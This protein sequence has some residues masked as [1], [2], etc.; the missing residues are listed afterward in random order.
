MDSVA[1]EPM[2]DFW[3]VELT[4]K[5]RKLQWPRS[6]EEPEPDVTVRLELR[7]ACL[8]AKAK[9]GER[10]VVELTAED[11]NGQEVTHA[12]L[13]LSVG[14]TEQSPLF[15]EVF[16]PVTFNLASGSGPL[17]IVGTVHTEFDETASD[18]LDEE[19]VSLSTPELMKNR[20][21]PAESPPSKAAKTM[22]LVKENGDEMETSVGQENG[23]EESDDE[24][25]SDSEGE[26]EDEEEDEEEKVTRKTPVKPTVVSKPKVKSAQKPPKS[27]AER[28]QF[29]TPQPLKGSK[30]SGKVTLSAPAT[31]E[32][33]S[34]SAKKIAK[35]TM[36]IEDMKEKLKKTPNLPKKLDKFGNYVQHNFKLTDDKIKKELW[37]FAQKMRA[38]K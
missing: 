20:K 1:I 35:S 24:E 9:P 30:A 26:E 23:S 12:I 13:S 15:L 21:R 36:S 19:D 34:K 17:H 4:G 18:E 8:G 10:N 32:Q 3:G 33:Q 28:P 37:E 11:E 27:L 31:P 38:A 14:G 7:Q 6:G 5:H 25:E 29:K 2:F 16:P 22:K